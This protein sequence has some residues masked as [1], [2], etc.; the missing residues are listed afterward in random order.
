MNRKSV[1]FITIVFLLITTTLLFFI[2]PEFIQ[3]RYYNQAI[4]DKGSIGDAF[5]GTLSPIIAWIA[6]ILTFLAFYIQYESNKKQ[7]KQFKKQ[8]EDTAIERFESRFFEMI[9]LHRENVEELN[10]QNIIKGRT[11]FT[12]MFFELKYIFLLFKMESEAQIQEKD[13]VTEKELLNISYLVFFY[14]IHDASDDV[15]RDLLANYKERDFFKAAVNRLKLAQ[16]QYS[17]WKKAP[18]KDEIFRLSINLKNL[19]VN[20]EPTFR[21]FTGHGQ[22]LSHYYRHLFQTV[23]YVDQ[24]KNELIDSQRKYEYVKMLRAQLSNFE[25]ILFYYNSCSVLGDS[26]KDKKNNLL[27]RYR[28]I[29]NLPLAFADFGIT[30]A[31]EY[32][33]ISNS[34]YE[35][36]KKFKEAENDG[37]A[38]SQNIK[39]GEVFFDWKVIQE[40]LGK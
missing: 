10:I 35:E 3:S 26:W 38:N 29:K 7:R 36:Y 20:F 11:V 9:R 5:G 24:Q 16:E 39:R 1:L 12:P 28:L 18:E 8:A 30:P 2:G 23:K 15:F 19:N 25:Q 21:P 32:K 4:D 6:A 37:S 13:S 40:K 33:D 14:G 31:V 17:A 22:K 34:S 27:V